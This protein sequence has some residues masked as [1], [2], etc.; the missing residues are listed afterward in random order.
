[1]CGVRRPSFCFY[2]KTCFGIRQG[3]WVVGSW[4]K[5]FRKEILLIAISAQQKL[6]HF[7]SFL[8]SITLDDNFFFFA[9]I[10]KWQI[11]V[12]ILGPATHFDM[13]DYVVRI[14]DSAG[15]DLILLNNRDLRIL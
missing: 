4:K 5:N 6:V 9:I 13:K 7:C 10:F 2:Q 14:L 8:L 12:H 1:M 3:E 11:A 15:K